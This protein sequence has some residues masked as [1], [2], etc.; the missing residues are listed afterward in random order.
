MVRVRNSSIID[1]VNCQSQSIAAMIFENKMLPLCSSGQILNLQYPDSLELFR[2]Q[3]KILI[4]VSL[5]G[6]LMF[7]NKKTKINQDIFTV[8][9][10]WNRPYNRRSLNSVLST[11]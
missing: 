11:Q 4:E 9:H 7:K 2:F 6:N 5:K 3:N 10:D 8:A 1:I